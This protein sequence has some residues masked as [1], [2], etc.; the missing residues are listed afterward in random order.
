[1]IDDQ[2][3]YYYYFIHFEAP[4]TLS[5]TTH[6]SQYQKGKTNLVYWSKR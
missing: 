1:M 5:R 4:W 3:R 2:D 6:V